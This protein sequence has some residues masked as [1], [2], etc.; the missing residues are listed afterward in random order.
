MKTT[1]YFPVFITV[2][3]MTTTACSDLEILPSVKPVGASNTQTQNREF[4]T[5][6]TTWGQPDGSYFVGIVSNVPSVDLSKTRISVVNNGKVTS[7]DNVL[8]VNKL[9]WVQPEGYFWAK[10]QNNILLLNYIGSTPTSLP[11]FP[12]DVIIAY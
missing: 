3:V 2:V 6:V 12:L 8:D 7:V 1:S 10:V 9:A 4:H 11:P 5:T